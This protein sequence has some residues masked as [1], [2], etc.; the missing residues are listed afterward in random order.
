MA[1]KI[2]RYTTKLLNKH[3]KKFKPVD[4][5]AAWMRKGNAKRW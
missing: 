3:R 1:K 4:S 2:K 5:L